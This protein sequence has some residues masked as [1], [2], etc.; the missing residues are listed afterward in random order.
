[1]IG[2]W[3]TLRV[4]RVKNVVPQTIYIATL[5]PTE[6]LLAKRPTEWLYLRLD[7][8]H[9]PVPELM[10]ENLMI[11][12]MMA[13]KGKMKVL[14]FFKDVNYFPSKTPEPPPPRVQTKRNIYKEYPI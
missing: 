13:I 6:R 11:S 12:I 4:A 10:F 8:T 2:T 7:P 3:H 14:I 1:M 5:G 9:P